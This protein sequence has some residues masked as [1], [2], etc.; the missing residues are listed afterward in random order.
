MR[1]FS[2]VLFLCILEYAEQTCELQTIAA[3]TRSSAFPLQD[4]LHGEGTG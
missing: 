2:S 3:A 4:V 1:A